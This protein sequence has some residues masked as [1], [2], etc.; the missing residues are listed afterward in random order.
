ME[1]ENDINENPQGFDHTVAIK[2]AKSGNI[3]GRNDYVASFEKQSDGTT[4]VEY[5]RPPGSGK[6][7][8]PSGERIEILGSTQKKFAINAEGQTEEEFDAANKPK[9]KNSEKPKD[10]DK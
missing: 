8:Y 6:K 1:N 5:E 10:G 2:D 3:I 4:K 9:H 7:F